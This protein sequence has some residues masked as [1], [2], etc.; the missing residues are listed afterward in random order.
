MTDELYFP[1]DYADSRSRFLK[2]AAALKGELVR[3]DVPSKTEEDLTVD[4]LWLPPS[5][6]NERLVVITT[7]VHGSETYAGSA[8]LQ[9][10]FDEILPR[11]DR[12]RTGV[13]LL[14]AMNPY[15]FKNHQRTTEARVNL[16][17]NCSVSG[18]IYEERNPDSARMNARFLTRRPIASKQSK[19]FESLRRDAKGI[20]FGEISLDE[21][22]KATAPGQY[23]RADDLEYGGHGPEPQIARFIARMR[24]LVPLFEDVLFF[25]VHTGLGDARRLHL[26]LDKPEE[27]HPE[28]F[29]QLFRT[30][31]DHE[32]YV[33]TPPDAEGFYEVKGAMNSIFGDLA[34]PNQRT[35]AL[36]MEYGTLGH[37]LEAQ[38]EGLNSM[39]V[40]HEGLC[41]GF[42]TPELAREIKYENFVRSYPQDDEWRRAVVG[43]AREMFSR[44]F[45]RAGI[46]A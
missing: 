4:S 38:L 13:Y 6:A 2:K 23:E 42:A 46:L 43:S 27:M 21:F 30:E 9:M 24:E 16:N 34:P 8:I 28:L 14:H 11:L 26:L 5:V 36:T 20:C 31:E 10:L 32:V 3:W 41:Y 7:G 1:K 18:A 19:L 39:M 25:D 15:G 17:R 35:C 29:K 40:D 37:S 22:V 44:V 12:T 33:F 45:T